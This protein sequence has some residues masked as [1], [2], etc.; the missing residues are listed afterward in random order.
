MFYV[1]S[2]VGD[3]TYSRCTKMGGRIHRTSRYNAH[4]CVYNHINIYKISI[5]IKKNR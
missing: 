1:Y 3:N 4:M 2:V 5:A